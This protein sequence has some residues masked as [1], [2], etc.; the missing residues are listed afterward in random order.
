MS[1]MIERVAKA[2]WDNSEKWVMNLGKQWEDVPDYDLQKKAI[3][4]QARAAI[5][6][7]RE[8]TAEMVDEGYCEAGGTDVQTDEVWRHMINAA[9][10]GSVWDN[11]KR[12]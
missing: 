11:I 2:I 10:G 7:M 4:V 8:P 6:A 9:L 1:E 3:R 5:E 12:R